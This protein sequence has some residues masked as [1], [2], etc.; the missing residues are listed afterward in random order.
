MYKVEI[1]HEICIG[2][3]ECVE[4]CPEEILELTKFYPVV[5]NEEGCVGCGVC[6]EVCDQEAII[7]KEVDEPLRFFFR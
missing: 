7:V 1:D 5:F 4:A 6:T 2:C 3:G